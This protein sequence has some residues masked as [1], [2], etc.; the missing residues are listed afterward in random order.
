M[1]SINFLDAFGLAWLLAH[2]ILGWHYGFARQIS[3]AAAVVGGFLVAHQGCTEVSAWLTQTFDISFPLQHIV[4][5]LGLVGIGYGLI[6][7]LTYPFRKL[8]EADPSPLSMPNRILGGVT[9]GIVATVMIYTLVSSL[10]WVN[11]RFDGKVAHWFDDYQESVLVT[12]VEENNA[13]DFLRLHEQSLLR[14]VANRSDLDESSDNI[15]SINSQEDDTF[16]ALVNGAKVLLDEHILQLIREQAWSELFQQE[17]VV[18]FLES[19]VATQAI[20]KNMQFK[21][22]R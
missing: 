20:A 15:A 9:S 22:S 8:I 5:F 14:I 17:E 11:E 3:T 7:L 19:D 1:D 13:F 16:S 10:T 2:V 21:R 4:V 6:T 12:F 18:L